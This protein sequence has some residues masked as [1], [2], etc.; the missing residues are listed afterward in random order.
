MNQFINISRL[1]Q[2]SVKLRSYG[3]KSLISGLMSS[4]A[5]R[6]R[7]NVLEVLTSFPDS[8]FILIGDS[9]EQDL[10]LYAALAADRELKERYE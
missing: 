2:G 6:K 1:P 9:G 7:S 8:Q 10:E 4:P 3:G 5:V